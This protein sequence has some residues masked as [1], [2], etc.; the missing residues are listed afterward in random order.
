MGTQIYLLLK[1]AT[2]CVSE[3]VL[4]KLW[5]GSKLRGVLTF[6]IRINE[7]QIMVGLCLGCHNSPAC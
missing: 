4:I 6:L 5:T 2:L 1:L 3:R 7:P